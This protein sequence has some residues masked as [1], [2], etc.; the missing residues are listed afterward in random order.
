MGSC[1]GLRR[2]FWASG[3]CLLLG[4]SPLWAATQE[5]KAGARA[6]A[7]QGEAAFN[8]KRWAD[9]I[10]LFSR[11]ESLVHSPVHLLFKAR[12]FAQL[13]QLVKARETYL[14]IIREQPSAPSPAITKA[15]DS[16]KAELPTIEPRLANLTIR[17]SGP[18]AESATVTMDDTALPSALI[19]LSQP[20]DPGAHRFR[21]RSG[22][23]QSEPVD[24]SLKEGGTGTVELALKPLGV[25]PALGASEGSSATVTGAESSHG[26]GLRT[27]SYVALGVGAV[28]LAVGTVFALSAK[29]K[30]DDANALCPSFPCPLTREQ[31]GTRDQLGSDG[32]SAKTL[33]LVGFIAGGVGVAAGATL[34]VLSRGSRS[35]QAEV[36]AFV[37]PGS[38]GVRGS[39]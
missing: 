10:D 11:A 19:G 13:G 25:S 14:E 21:A 36:H 18:G 30:Y 33:S 6:A 31:A 8:Q 34:F 9:A 26:N 15:Q 1:R 2:T 16:A 23:L 7:T 22:D 39:F 27:A 4:S 20:V 17:V 38:L 3:L 5:E 32:D 24:L 35:E 12:A 28:G 37:G 29:S